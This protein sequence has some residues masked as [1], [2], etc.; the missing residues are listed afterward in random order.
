MSPTLGVS[1]GGVEAL[2]ASG[3]LAVVRSPELRR[4]PAGLSS[5]VE[6]LTEDEDLGGDIGW[7]QLAEKLQIEMSEL[8]ALIRTELEAL[9]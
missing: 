4:R 7:Q 2:M 9:G 1:V 5:L 3:R 8:R 6:E